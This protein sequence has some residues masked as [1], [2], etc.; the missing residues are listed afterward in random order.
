MSESKFKIEVLDTS[1]S[2]TPQRQAA[3]KDIMP[4]FPFS[5][6]ISGRSG[7]GK[8]NAMLNI[9]TRKELYGNF[10]HTILVFSPTAGSYDDTYKAL[11]IPEEN[12][13]REFTGE[14]L[15]DIIEA[16]KKLID[17]QGVEKVAKTSRVCLILDDIIAERSFLESPM[18][19]RLFSLL[20]HYL[21]SI[22]VLVQSYTKL[23]RALRVNCNAV[24]I[25]PSLQSEREILIK[26]ITPSGIR[27]RDFEKVIDY[28]TEGQ[29]D[30]LYINNHAPPG[31]RIRKNLDEIVDLNKFKRENISANITNKD[32]QVNKRTLEVDRERREID[33]SQGGGIKEPGRSRTAR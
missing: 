25:F 2:K 15:E 12:F 14:L 24:I 6:M 28:C 33:P 32:E 19:L 22:V 3:K 16:R 11:K 4:K 20:R 29:Y 7:S 27:M 13:V 5:M 9:L 1:K 18:A 26:E 30:F 31:K 17:E 23:P 8:T 21:C 10:F